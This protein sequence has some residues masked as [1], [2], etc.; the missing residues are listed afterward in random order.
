[1]KSDNEDLYICEIKSKINN[2]LIYS[3]TNN[4]SFI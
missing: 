2:I 1:M 4:N 3:Y